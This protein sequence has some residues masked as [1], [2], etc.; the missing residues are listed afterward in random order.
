MKPA[1]SAGKR[2]QQLHTLIGQESESRVLS[3]SL[4]EEVQSTAVSENCFQFS[5]ESRYK[6]INLFLKKK[7][8]KYIVTGLKFPDLLLLFWHCM[9]TNTLI[10]TYIA[11]YKYQVHIYTGD[12]WGAGTDANVLITLFGEDGDSEE[13]KLD[14]NKNNFESGQ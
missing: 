13:K 3:Q 4:R 2:R 5:L 7:G 6:V 11:D 1:L 10:K 8:D 12:K 14:N 9:T